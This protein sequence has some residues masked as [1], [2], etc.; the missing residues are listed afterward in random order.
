MSKIGQK[1]LDEA[2]QLELSE[3][4]ELTAEL[5]ASLHGEPD[6]CCLEDL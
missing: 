2:L 1:L 6:G 3:R 4:V 5:L